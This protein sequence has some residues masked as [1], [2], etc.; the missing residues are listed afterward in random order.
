MSKCLWCRRNEV[1]THSAKSHGICSVCFGREVIKLADRQEKISVLKTI[2]GRYE[3]ISK[4]E[5]RD[6]RIQMYRALEQ[7][8]LIA[9]EMIKHIK[10]K[11]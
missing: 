4:I 7:L 8:I 5:N 3:L 6:T 2:A 9:D 10:E 11:L 1:K